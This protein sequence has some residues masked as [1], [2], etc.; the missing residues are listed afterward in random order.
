MSCKEEFIKL[1]QSQVGYKETGNNNTKYSR[2]F[3]VEAWQFFNYK[4]NGSNCPW[5]AIFV[6]WLFCQ[7]S[8]GI[9]KDKVRTWLGLP[10]PK[11]NDAAGCTQFSGYLNKKGYKVDKTKGQAGDIIFFGNTEHVGMIEKVEGGKY[12]TIEG[13]KSNMVKRCSYSISSTQIHSVYHPKW[14][15]VEPKPVPA[16]EPT[17]T[18]TAKNYEVKVGSFLA[19]RSSPT[20]NAP[21]K[22]RLFNGAIVTV[23]EKSN[24]FGKI[25][26]NLWCSMSYLTEK[27]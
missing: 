26:P 13:N 8:V 12:Y 5:C 20:V 23:T 10:A 6:L 17:P 18:V 7:N 27:K 1:A 21:E 3:D 24:G 19:L 4:K 16:P 22:G 15:L 9:G 14:E 2:W 25:A 11:Y